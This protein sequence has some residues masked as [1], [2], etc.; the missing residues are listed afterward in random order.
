MLSLSANALKP[1]TTFNHSNSFSAFLN[2]HPLFLIP[3]PRNSTLKTKTSAKPN[4][5]ASLIPANPPPK[6]LQPYQP[7]RPPPSPL[8]AKYSSLD[9]AARLEVLSSRAG[10]WYEYAPLITSLIR[11]GYAPSSIEEVTGISGVEQNRLV[12]G[13][14][15]RD[16]LI[17]SKTGPELISHFETGGAELLYEIRLLSTTQRAAAAHYIIQN[18]FDAG[19]AEDL[20]RSMKDFP[21][22]RGEKGWEN[23]DYNLP[24]DCLAFLYFRQA[25]EHKNPS[26]A[27][28]AS[29]QSA[30]E[31][32]ESE[33]AKQAVLR[34]MEGDTSAGKGDKQEA[35]I[36][37][38]RVPVVRMK[39]GEVA[40]STTVVV[41]P[42]CRAE[43]RDKEIVEAPWVSKAGGEFG[44]VEADKGW[45][46]WIVLPGWEPV[47]I[48]GEGGVV[49]SFP[50]ARALPWRVNRWYKEEA[51]LV[52][53]DR[54]RKGVEVD[55]GFY[56][57]AVD[58]SGDGRGSGLK[59]E[60]GSALKQRGVGESLGTVVLVVRPPKEDTE[61]QM[62]EDDD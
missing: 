12:V 25:K 52:V 29:L 22:R 5:S 19:G 37:G 8:P 45:G 13:A 16:S 9:A 15:V 1:I 23:F 61:D 49:V 48:L 46:R 43:G 7:F 54:A 40:E 47:A 34:E 41:L 26:D 24:G 31:A 21:R 14:Q 57:V 55:D 53:A 11:E 39:T 18:R 62:L 10:L 4:I 27:R 59:V 56:L 35:A 20:A 33:K 60:K 38:V 28:T 30:L 58:D 42:V 17:E 6:N 50:D 2:P 3:H 44:E 32:A 36:D 51:I